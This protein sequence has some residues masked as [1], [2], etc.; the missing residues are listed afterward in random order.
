[1]SARFSKYYLAYLLLL[2]SCK[3]EFDHATVFKELPAFNKL[4]LNS[5]F[6]VFL[7][8]ENAHSIRIEAD[9]DVV[10]DISFEVREGTLTVRNRQRQQWLRPESNKVNLYITAAA[11][12]S[13]SPGETC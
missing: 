11:L 5:V 8:Q 7:I 1:M 12:N 13:I 2:I 10:N 6:N 4:E 9:D 3:D